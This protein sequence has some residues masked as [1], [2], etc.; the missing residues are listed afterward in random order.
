MSFLQQNWPRGQNR[1]C[2]EERGIEGRGK[3]LGEE[4]G[5]KGRN[6]PSNVC[7]YE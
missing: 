7:T 4:Y 1:F 3:G 6:N 2:L 5:A